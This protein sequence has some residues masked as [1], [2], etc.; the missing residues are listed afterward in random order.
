MDAVELLSTDIQKPLSSGYSER[1]TPL[2]LARRDEQLHTGNHLAKKGQTCQDTFLSP[3]PF[4]VSFTL[5]RGVRLV[6]FR[7]LHSLQHAF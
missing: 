5:H 2:L 7:G 1:T 3:L 4:T 6:V